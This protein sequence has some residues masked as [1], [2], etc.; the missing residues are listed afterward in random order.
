MNKNILI[1]YI[2]DFAN[3]GGQARNIAFNNFFR[4]KGYKIYNLMSKKNPLKKVLN[5]MRFFRILLNAKQSRILIHGNLIT[6]IT[7]LNRISSKKYG[8]FIKRVLEYAAQSNEIIIEINDLRYEQSLDLEIATYSSKVID[9]ENDILYKTKGIKYI[10]ASNKMGSYIGGKYK[11]PSENIFI[12]LNGGPKLE[13][14]EKDSLTSRRESPIKYAYA[15]TLNS[16]RQ[17]K[18]MIELFR[19][20]EHA[21]LI[22]L[23][24]GGDWLKLYNTPTNVKYIGELEEQL[25]QN[26]VSKC[27]IGII[28][29]DSKRFYYNLCY[30]TKASFYLTAGIPFLSTELDELKYVFEERE[31]AIFTDMS[32]WRDIIN[33]LTLEDIID[34]K[35]K[36]EKEKNKFE[37]A[38]ILE[39]LEM[40]LN[41]K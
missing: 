31:L 4:Q 9:M 21:E 24:I 3:E 19:G 22:L 23:G 17:I 10:F 27:D 7:M 20:C 41:V 16:G 36:V 2:D 18:E 38:T 29:Y 35:L 13:V 11:L 33:T 37:W 8:A 5:L 30:P 25:A 26:Y 14:V 40:Q 6:S 34:M 1:T 15:G 12:A 28:P 32:S 39:N